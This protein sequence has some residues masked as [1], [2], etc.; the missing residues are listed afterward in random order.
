MRTRYVLRSGKLVEK[1]EATPR[2]NYQILSDIKPFITQDG[3]EITSRS[4]LRDY[5]RANG[6]R[7]VGT[8]WTGSERP[9]YLDR[10]Q[11]PR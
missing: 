8:D 10:R 2:Y 1:T 7:Q 9:K 3:V 5:E 4:K 11:D 6:V